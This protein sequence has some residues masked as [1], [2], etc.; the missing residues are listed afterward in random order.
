M[1]RKEGQL[2]LSQMDFNHAMVMV[3]VQTLVIKKL[4]TE[5]K[6]QKLE[7]LLLLLGE[8]VI[9]SY[10]NDLTCYHKSN[11][12]IGKTQ[13]LDWKILRPLVVAKPILSKMVSF[14]KLI[15]DLSIYE[16]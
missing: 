13:I 16:T 11:I 5:S 10:I 15:E 2:Y 12:F 9:K 4:L 6:R 14:H 7:S 1:I 8:L 3:M